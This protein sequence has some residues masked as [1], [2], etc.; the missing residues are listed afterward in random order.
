VEA[1]PVGAEGSEF[2][3]RLGQP[4]AAFRLRVRQHRSGVQA[5]D[6]PGPGELVHVDDDAIDDRPHPGDSPAGARGHGREQ[7]LR[8]EEVTGIG[9]ALWRARI[10]IRD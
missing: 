2:Q 6:P 3:V 5:L 9:M 1:P 8:L 7:R 4:P 10:G